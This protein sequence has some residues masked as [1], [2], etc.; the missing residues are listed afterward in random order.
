MACCAWA[1]CQLAGPSLL[2][3]VPHARAPAE[4]VTNT[5]K[6]LN[7]QGPPATTTKCCHQF[8]RRPIITESNRTPPIVNTMNNASQNTNVPYVRYGSME[9]QQPD[10]KDTDADDPMRSVRSSCLCCWNT[11]PLVPRDAPLPLAK[12]VFTLAVFFVISLLFTF[13]YD[14]GVAVGIAKISWYDL[15]NFD[16]GWIGWS[17]L[18][19]SEIAAGESLLLLPLGLTLGAIAIHQYRAFSLEDPIPRCCSCGS[20]TTTDVAGKLTTLAIVF[21]VFCLQGSLAI[22]VITSPVYDV[23]TQYMCAWA[24]DSWN[25]NPQTWNTG[26]GACTPSDFDDIGCANVIE[27]HCST[28]D[29]EEICNDLNVGGGDLC[30]WD[31]MSC[32]PDQGVDNTCIEVDYHGY[33]A[34]YFFHCVFRLISFILGVMIANRSNKLRRVMAALSTKTVHSTGTP[35]DGDNCNVDPVGEYVVVRMS[36]RAAQRKWESTSGTQS[37]VSNDVCD[38]VS[39]WVSGAYKFL[40]SLKV[41]LCSAPS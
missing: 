12:S 15:F 39:D 10:E 1:A 32:S 7:A 36:V 20:Q 38:W 14:I 27:T 22:L 11:G 40:Y 29:T 8:L 2:R 26:L 34:L 3:R 37:E 21:V 4:H 16:A 41:Q 17:D 19:F 5:P 35:A 28:F 33:Y 24:D 30:S 13:F 9:P 23:T 18:R 31:G 25:G 6:V